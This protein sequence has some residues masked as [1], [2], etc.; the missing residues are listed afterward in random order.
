MKLSS[1]ILTSALAISMVANIG[2]GYKYFQLRN[3]PSNES[4]LL[5]LHY[6]Q[7]HNKSGGE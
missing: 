2:L 6:S 4:M 3:T 5:S 7:F 1:G